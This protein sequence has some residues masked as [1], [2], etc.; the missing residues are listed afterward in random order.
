[1]GQ[2]EAGLEIVCG[3]LPMVSWRKTVAFRRTKEAWNQAPET[4]TERKDM[5]AL[6]LCG[7]VLLLLG[8]LRL[9]HSLNHLNAGGTIWIAQ[10]LNCC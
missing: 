10:E 4:G 7:V 3:I 9:I 2:L 5:G 6:L 1:M 8:V